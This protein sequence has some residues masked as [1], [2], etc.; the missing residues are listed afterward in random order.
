MEEC[1]YDLTAGRI[2]TIEC[3]ALARESMRD[4]YSELSS[5]DWHKRTLDAL[6]HVGATWQQF[7]DLLRAF[8]DDP[9]EDTPPSGTIRGTGVWSDGPRI[10]IFLDLDGVVSPIVLSESDSRWAEIAEDPLTIAGQPPESGWQDWTFETM[11]NVPVPRELLADIAQLGAQSSVA[12]AWLTTWEERANWLFEDLAMPDR[13]PVHRFR[14]SGDDRVTKWSTVVAETEQNPVPFV[15]IDDHV[16]LDE[17]RWARH[18]DVDSL[19]IRTNTFHG[20]TRDCWEHIEAWIAERLGDSTTT[21]AKYDN[22][23]EPT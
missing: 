7:S 2:S 23:K 15:W 5:P 21:S 18:L 20:I 22:S 12:L 10:R 3:I 8:S 19:V 6:T 1:F 4:P 13:L 17:Y 16:G 14:W 9:L 11:D